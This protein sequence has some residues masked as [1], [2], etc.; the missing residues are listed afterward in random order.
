[1]KYFLSLV[2]LT[3]VGCVGNSGRNS[4]SAESLG[5]YMGQTYTVK[6]GFYKDCTGIA[7][8]YSDMD[9]NDDEAYLTN[10]TCANSTINFIHVK[11]KTLK[12]N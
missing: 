11:A 7:T 1:M 4:D 12:S 9:Y 8:G 10:V 6:S 3:M 2:L 5:I